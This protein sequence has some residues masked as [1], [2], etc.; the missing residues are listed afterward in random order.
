LPF[1]AGTPDRGPDRI[2]SRRS[3]PGPTPRRGHFGVGAAELLK[4]PLQ[5]DNSRPRQ[6]IGLYPE[7]DWGKGMIPEIHKTRCPGIIQR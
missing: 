1:L 5:K 3:E 2:A 7:P 6:A 4:I